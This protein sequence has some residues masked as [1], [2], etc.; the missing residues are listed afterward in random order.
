MKRLKVTHQIHKGLFAILFLVALFSIAQNVK[1]LDQEDYGSETTRED[2]LT[3]FTMDRNTSLTLLFR[4][5]FEQPVKLVDGKTKL[6]GG[7]WEDIPHL[8]NYVGD[9]VGDEVYTSLTAENSHG[10]TRSLKQVV[11]KPWRRT[12]HRNELN[13]YTSDYET[14]ELLISKWLLYPEDLF[15]PPN[16]QLVGIMAHREVSSGGWGFS[17]G[18]AWAK[19]SSGYE[20][21]YVDC[22]DYSRGDVYSEWLVWRVQKRMSLPRGEW[23]K[24]EDYIYR[25]PSDGVYKLWLDDELI[26]DIKGKPTMKNT[27][28]VVH[29]RLAKIYINANTQHYPFYHYVD[30]IEIWS[31]K[32]QT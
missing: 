23:F 5:G 16:N 25:H 4:S 19:H 27:M 24:L 22:V 2:I 28:N 6:Q 26:F 20:Y 14:R 17:V 18:F 30:D 13:Y 11:I 10:G 21:L 15:I 1:A 32:Q 31:V 7:G 8:L 29:H 3:G 9:V 12:P